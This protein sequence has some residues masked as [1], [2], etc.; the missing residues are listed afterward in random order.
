[1][2]SKDICYI[3]GIKYM[4]TRIAAQTWKMNIRDVQKACREG[5]VKDAN[6]DSSDRYIIRADSP[7]PLES[8]Q[9]AQLLLLTLR[10]K[11]DPSLVVDMRLLRGN[12]IRPIYEYL[13]GIGHIQ[14]IDSIT[15]NDRLPYDVILTDIGFNVVHQ[16]KEARALSALDVVKT[17]NTAFELMNN[18]ITLYKLMSA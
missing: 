3:D 16:S 7:K 10:L 4:S 8:N 9:I 18:A 13:S 6:R 2:A 5:R 17:I 11:N 1:M 15:E 14:S 12:N